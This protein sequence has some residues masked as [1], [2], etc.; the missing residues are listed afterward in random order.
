MRAR[1][2]D[3]D[4]LGTSPPRRRDVLGY[5]WALGL[6]ALTVP[7]LALSTAGIVRAQDPSTAAGQRFMRIG[8]G[9]AAGHYFPIG[10]MIANA[11]SRPPGARPCEKGGSCGVPGLIAVAQSTGGS[12]DNIRGLAAGTLNLALCQ[13]DIA[14]WARSGSAVFEDVGPMPDLVAL[15]RL[16]D[17][18]MHLVVRANSDV[19]RV[20]D[21]RGRRVALGELGSG[22]LVDA[23]LV[24]AAHG[25]TE[26]DVEPVYDR[27]GPAADQ[28]VA[29]E[30]EAFFFV[31]AAPVTVVTELAEALPIR[32]LD[33]NGETFAGMSGR[34]PYLSAGVIPGGVYAGVPE[35]VSTLAVAAVLVTTK[36]LDTETAHGI[37]RAIW[38]PN[39]RG[40]FG[41]EDEPEM[42]TPAL[43]PHGT[44]I[45]LHAGA[46][47]YYEEAGYLP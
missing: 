2:P 34:H 33:L 8:T 16:Y 30:I 1:R 42:L 27:P 14:Y 40:L 24:L 29:G 25:L 15:A 41:S 38:H 22:T 37:T 39:V 28:L 6:G 45:P 10:G 43:A 46:Q 3:A 21:L 35:P 26:D 32:L 31:G 12:V 4:A 19:T 18:K 9:S 23:R 36:T 17:E 47:R 13:A 44:G 11:I 7:A 20:E 5:A